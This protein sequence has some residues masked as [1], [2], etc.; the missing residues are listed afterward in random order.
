MEHSESVK[1]YTIDSIEYKN[2]SYLGKYIEPL[3]LLLNLTCE[4][5]SQRCSAVCPSLYRTHGL[6]PHLRSH[7]LDTGIRHVPRPHTGTRIRLVH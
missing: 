5:S 6:Y 1:V 3:I 2:N 4:L 7:I